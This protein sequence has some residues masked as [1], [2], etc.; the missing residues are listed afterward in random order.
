MTSGPTTVSTEDWLGDDKIMPFP[1][2]TDTQTL[3]ADAEQKEPSPNDSADMLRES[4]DGC[5]QE[6]S[7][8]N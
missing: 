8:V 4:P 6:V 5:E 1:I 3:S 7:T 2:P